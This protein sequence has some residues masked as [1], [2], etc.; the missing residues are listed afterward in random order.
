MEVLSPGPN[1][2][3]LQPRLRDGTGSKHLL[4]ARHVTSHLGYKD[5]EGSFFPQE[6]HS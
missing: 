6:I 3:K 4:C 1:L 2:I 5:G